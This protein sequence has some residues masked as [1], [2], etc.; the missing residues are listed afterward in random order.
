MS[1]KKSGGYNALNP[2]FSIIYLSGFCI[3][4]MERKRD[5]DDKGVEN[6]TYYFNKN[7]RL[8]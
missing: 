4:K 1:N 8:D 6:N 2:N 3:Q 7:S 5:V